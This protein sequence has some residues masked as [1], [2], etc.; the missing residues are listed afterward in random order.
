MENVA[1]I[2]SY[3]KGAEN[4]RI[5]G[6]SGG[7]FTVCCSIWYRGN[8]DLRQRAFLLAR[9][10]KPPYL[11]IC[12]SR[13]CYNNVI[14]EMSNLKS[15]KTIN[16]INMSSIRTSA[17]ACMILLPLFGVTWLFGLL[18]LGNVGGVA[19]RYVFTILN[20]LQGFMIFVFHCVRSTELR[21]A[22]HLKLFKWESSNSRTPDSNSTPL[23]KRQSS[24]TMAAPNKV[25]PRARMQGMIHSTAH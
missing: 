17:R 22:V 11:D 19:G 23:K 13:G 18:S 25:I 12:W 21:A 4:V 16:S 3:V 20:S 14:R 6:T 15:V 2:G 1:S 8:F 9:S 10:C 7:G 5:S 24:K